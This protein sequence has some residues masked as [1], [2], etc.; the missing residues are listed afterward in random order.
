MSDSTQHTPDQLKSLAEAAAMLP[1]H[2][3]RTDVPF[4]DRYAFEKAMTPEHYLSVLSK[5]DELLATLRWIK[6]NPGVHPVNLGRII[7][8]AIAKASQ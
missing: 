4:T 3:A 1:W 7:D 2:T 8:S 6:A 5:L